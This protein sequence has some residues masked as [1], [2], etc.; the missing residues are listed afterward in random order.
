MNVELVEAEDRVE[1]TGVVIP[2]PDLD[3]ILLKVSAA[4]EGKLSLELS[5]GEARVLHNF[6]SERD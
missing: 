4:A 6:L 1:M 5:P 2:P 3:S